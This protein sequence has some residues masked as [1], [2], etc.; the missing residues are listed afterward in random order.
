MYQSIGSSVAFEAAYIKKSHLLLGLY[1]NM[2]K[3]L[4][5]V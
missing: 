2:H 1:A 4:W 5:R 3:E